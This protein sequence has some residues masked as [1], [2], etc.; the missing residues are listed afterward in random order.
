MYRDPLASPDDGNRFVRDGEVWSIAFGGRHGHLKHTRGLADLALLLSR[1]GEEIFAVQLM[2][3]MEVSS[4]AGADP[5]FDERARADIRARLRALERSIADAEESGLDAESLRQEQRAI[6]H[7]LRAATGLGRRRRRLGDSAERARKAVSGRIRESIEKIRGPL[8]ELARHLDES[9]S[10]GSFCA[11]RP[12][13]PT[14]W[15]L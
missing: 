8:P 2:D 5:I 6:L 14:T 4:P 3:G 7:E 15:R 10:T 12:A 9:I 13:R 11:Y 1:P